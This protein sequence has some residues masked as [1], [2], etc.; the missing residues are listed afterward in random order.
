MDF[1]PQADW[2]WVYNN[3]QE[4]FMVQMGDQ[5]IEI[6]FKPNLLVPFCDSVIP[7]TVEDVANYS[8]LF[9]KLNSEFDSALDTCQTVLHLL[10]FELFHK[11]VMPKSWLFQSAEIAV[12]N[13]QKGEV[14][15]LQSKKLNET[16]EYLI[17]ESSEQFVICMLLGKQH[18][19][20]PRKVF[21]Q[22]QIVKVTSDK[23]SLIKDEP[24]S[25]WHSYQIA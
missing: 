12:K 7:F 22:F 6:T 17:V 10:A 14:F 8:L 18:K 11:P 16:E 19:L 25:N 4:E 5:F 21:N 20:T 1:M 24:E 3:E 13:P 2:Q 9:E 15:L 23:L